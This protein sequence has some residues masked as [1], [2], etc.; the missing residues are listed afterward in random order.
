M[1]KVFLSILLFIAIY[2]ISAQR[3]AFGPELGITS[4]NLNKTDVEVTTN[5]LTFSGGVFFDYKFNRWLSLRLG[6]NYIEGSKS[7][8][9]SDTTSLD[10]FLDM[11]ELGLDSSM[12]SLLN[13]YVD[14]NAIKY[15]SGNTNLAYLRVP[16]SFV[17]SPNEKINFAIG[18]YYSFLLRAHTRMK[19]EMDIPIMD[20]FG[21]AIESQAFAMLVFKQMFPEYYNQE[22]EE[23]TKPTGYA[24]YD[25]GING[26]VSYNFE[27]NFF[28][29]LNYSRGFVDFRTRGS[30][31]ITVKTA[32]NSLTTL[33][34]G[35]TFGKVF[36]DR[37]KKRYDI[38][39]N[40][41]I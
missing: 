4:I 9:E 30:D 31:K 29:K 11:I 19:T 24:M 5:K 20:V 28:L 13:N 22:L 7:W 1:K 6:A 18:G 33:T 12:T 32:T 3:I 41:K 35:Y 10:N 23:S 2:N 37:V 17:L 16:L 27:N 15:T 21:K 39:T 38:D 14:L 36:T 26:G 25:Y 8:Y 40:T 34:I